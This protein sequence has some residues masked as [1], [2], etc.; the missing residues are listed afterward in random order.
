LPVSNSTFDLAIIGGGPAGYVAAI[1]A[2]QYGLK[3][4]L[5]EKEKVGGTCLHQ[6]CIPTKTLLYSAELYRKC[7]NATEFGIIANGLNINYPQFHRR[8][9]YIV[10]RLF[11]GVQFLLKKNGVEVF[12]AEGHIASPQEVLL[13]RDKTEINRIKAKN[14]VLATGSVPLIHETIPY[15]KK[16]ILTSDDIL[17]R[18]EIPKS[19]II[20]GGGAVGIE[21]ACLFNALGTKVTVVE[22]LECVLPSE[23]REISES[24][25]KLLIRGGVDVLTHTSLEKVEIENGVK[26][27]IKREKEDAS[28]KKEFINAELLLLA[29]GRTPKLDNSGIKDLGLHFDGKYL[30][31]NEVM[32]TS[33]SGIYAIGDITGPPLL[34]HKAM[35]EGLMLAAHLAGKETQVANRKN[36]PRV[37]YSFP[38]VASI[39]L[40]QKEAEGMGYKVKI[41][42]F[43]FSANSMAIIEGESSD[44]FVKIIT[45]EKYGEVLGVHAM[46]PH[47]GEWMWGV[48]LN[49]LLEGTIQEISNT[50][51]P[52]PTL[53]EALF[54][55]AHSI[56]DKPRE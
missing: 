18:E 14:I 13:F 23:D 8:K 37:V 17:I 5:V 38:Q 19:M 47:V 55:A 56:I 35:N 21:F 39:G 22:F 30:Q 7:A 48:S 25:K 54:E 51:F 3:T 46:G 26:A 2:A 10:K 32:E 28:G 16:Y 15:D 20:V 36:I 27:E 34:A 12:G 4:A 43:P 24:T 53:S 33:Q 31:T 29:M 49:T 45:E 40:T 11:Q 6:G 44:G 9:E 42:K 52:H 41:G 1:K 50:I